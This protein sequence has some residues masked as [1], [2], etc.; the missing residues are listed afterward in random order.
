MFGALV[1]ER[2]PLTFNDL[3]VGVLL[4][5]RDVGAFAALGLV[6]WLIVGLPRMRRPQREAI[7]GWQ[8]RLFFTFAVLSALA[9]AVLGGVVLFTAKPPEGQPLL[10]Y[11]DWRLLAGA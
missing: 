8:V 1:I 9:Y 10:V 11:K 7:P 6:L 2:E 5:A 4:W 3:P